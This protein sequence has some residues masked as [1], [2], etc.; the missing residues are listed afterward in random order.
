M[1]VNTSHKKLRKS[2]TLKTLNF[3][4]STALFMITFAQGYVIC[5]GNL[6]FERT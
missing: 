1:A 5:E 4:S 2:S 6:C 3:L